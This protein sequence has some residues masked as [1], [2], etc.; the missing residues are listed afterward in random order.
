M[1]NDF[2]Q[3]FELQDLFL[4][5]YYSIKSLQVV[6]WVQSMNSGPFFSSHQLN[7]GCWYKAKIKEK[8][9][10]IGNIAHEVSYLRKFRFRSTMTVT[11][12]LSTL[13]K[14]GPI[15]FP[16]QRQHH[17]LTFWDWIRFSHN[18]SPSQLQFCLLTYQLRLEV[19]RH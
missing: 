18:S 1:E 12:F 13:K 2:G 8:H 5:S 11:T 4:L 9:I 10:P 7:V 19:T 16:N 17:T 14:K 3:L 6:E 15:I